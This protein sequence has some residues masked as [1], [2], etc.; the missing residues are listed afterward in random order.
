M[1]LK[2]YNYENGKRIYHDGDIITI[3]GGDEPDRPAIV[4][5]SSDNGSF[6][7]IKTHG[8]IG[9]A[10]RVETEPTGKH[11][12]LSPMF[13]AIESCKGPKE[14]DGPVSYS[15]GDIVWDMRENEPMIVFYKYQ[16]GDIVTLGMGFFTLGAP[17]SS[18]APTG[19]HFD[20]TPMFKAIS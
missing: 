11:F 7:A 4:F 13:E 3:K 18:V 16:D 5:N 6:S 1:I 14:P 9:A 19:V 10:E 8:F 17:K 15:I 20:L 12:D 2:D